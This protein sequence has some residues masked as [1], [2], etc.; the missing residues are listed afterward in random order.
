MNFTA[1]LDQVTQRNAYRTSLI[2]YQRAQRDY[3]LA[4]D[5]VKFDVRSAWRLVDVGRQAYEIQRQSVRIAA[6]AVRSDG[7]ND[8]EEPRCRLD[9]E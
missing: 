1:P 4:E 6:P 5:Q 7:G 8:N 9:G 2:A 3:M